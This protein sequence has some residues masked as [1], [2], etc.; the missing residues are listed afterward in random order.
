[1][2]ITPLCFIITQTSTFDYIMP[3]LTQ[4]ELTSL[5]FTDGGARR[6]PS[7][8]ELIDNNFIKNDLAA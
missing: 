7:F 2:T 3:K 1:M 5:L 8:L 6:A 4:A